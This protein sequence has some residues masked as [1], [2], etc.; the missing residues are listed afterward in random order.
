VQARPLPDLQ[1]CILQPGRTAWRTVTAEASGVIVDAA[2]YYHALYW[3]T[4]HARRSILMSGWEF[5]RGVPLLRGADVPAGDEVRFLKFLNG[6]CERNPALHV[7]L[8]VWNFH[9]VLAAER[10][11][12]QRVFFH[13]MTNERLHFRVLDSAVAGGSHHQ[14]FAVIDGRLAFLGGMDVCEGRWDDRRHLAENPLRRNRGWAQKPY[15]DVQAYM[16][17]GDAP[18]VLEQ[19]F[20]HRWRQAGGTPPRLPPPLRGDDDLRPRGALALGPA[21]IALSRTQPERGRTIRE[22]ER[23]FVD[24]IT[25]AERLIYVETQYFSSRRIFDALVRRLRDQPRSGLEIV[26]VVNERAEAVKE[27]VAVGLR[28]LEIITA[29]REV[30]AQMGQ[31]FGC[32]YTVPDGAPDDARRTTY[33]HS[34]VMVVDDRF[35]TVGSANLTNRSM[36]V[37]SEL[38]ASWEAGTADTRLARA[39]RRV[40]VSLLAEHSGLSGLREV[41][42]L[43]PISGLVARLDDLAARP[44]ARLRAHQPPTPAQAAMLAAVDP[45]ALPFDPD[46][47]A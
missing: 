41:R 24:A 25:A 11:W 6:L 3:A 5:D 29:L 44:R 31:A 23:L 18:I 17:G 43:A 1:S 20:F 7:C 28:Q 21:R 34:K 37:D 19:Y 30:A 47:V 15:H 8:L 22:V 38:H 9:L 26:I 16:G 46:R 33:I 4:R 14:K 42:A 39:I 2:D 36:G 45:Q 35:L 40:R 13:W 12:L 27:E 10:E 32:Y